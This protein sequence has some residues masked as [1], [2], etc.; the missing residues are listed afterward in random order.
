MLFNS[1]EF[2]LLFLP[3]VLVL[4][5][6]VQ[7]MG[8]RSV[9][10][11][12]SV[13]SLAFYASWNVIYLP[14][15][16]GSIA[17]NFLI[18]RALTY[19]KLRVFLVAGLLFNLGLLGWY[20][21]ANFVSEQLGVKGW[22]TVVLPL[23]ISFFTF[24]QIAFLVDTWKGKVPRQS[25]TDYLLFVSFFPQLIAGP[26][27]HHAEIMPQF[28]KL[29]RSRE[30]DL[31]RGISFFII[32]LFKKT[33]IADGLGGYSTP[34]FLAVQQGVDP[35]FFEAWGGALAYTGQLYFDFS[36]Y[37]DMA[38]GLAAMFGI[39]LPWNFNSPYKA[40]NII[41][42]WRRWHI[43]LSRFLRDY[44][45]IPLGGNRKGTFRRYLNILLTMGL[46]GIWHGAGWTFMVWGLL[47]GLY[48]IVNHIWRRYGFLLGPIPATVFTFLAVVVGW[49]VFR[50]E[51]FIT[52]G[53]MLFGILGVNGIVIN[54]NLEPVLSVFKSWGLQFGDTGS[55][56][57]DGLLLIFISLA[58]VF[59]APNSQELM[60]G[61]TRFSWKP[62]RR[63]A[64][65]LAVLAIISF[66]QL[67]QVSE[68]LYFEF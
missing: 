10:T 17:V 3:T 44:L 52:A 63:W 5:F 9:V 54:D 41:E 24:Q 23:A 36:G 32:G 51:N 68:F 12:L 38:I 35:S 15:L 47:H 2:I 58:L 26:I 39:R 49:V 42:F 13:A 19:K 8:T 60:E 62:N 66:M 11:T 4:H 59:F 28:S 18:G 34:V 50:A 14:L 48:L 22:E 46:G 20:K 33:F 45:Y 21:Y 43:T 30:R 53:R 57:D 55:F 27:V 31:A 37:S 67:G 1:Y 64:F 25:F 7:R 6:L 16:L 29:S 40:K 56:N 61:K 65:A